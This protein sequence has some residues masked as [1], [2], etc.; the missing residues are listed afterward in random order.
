[1][2]KLK[3]I[4]Y[5]EIYKYFFIGGINTVFGYGV[6]AFLLFLDFHYSVAVL[7][8]TISGVVFNFQT[9]GKFVFQNHSQHLIVKFILVYIVIYT[10]NVSL[11]SLVDIFTDNL[12]LSGVIVILPVSYLG[13]IL[14]K[15]FVW[16]GN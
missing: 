10:V 9:Y 15:R 3:S 12:Y 11:L 1:M 6:F 5:I 8:A 14:N 2:V 7:V 16:K 13:Y 4:K